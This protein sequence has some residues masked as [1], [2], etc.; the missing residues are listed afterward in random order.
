MITTNGFDWPMIV[1][2]KDFIALPDFIPITF[3]LTVLFSALG[4]VTTFLLVSKLGP[5]SKKLILDPR[6]SDNKFV[7]AIDVAKNSKYGV[8]D[9][10][11]KVKAEGAS[12]VFQKEID[13]NQ[14]LDL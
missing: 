5:G 6:Y 13:N 12:E 8:D 9:I 4:M 7:V 14:Y 10:I 2:G 3:E 11:S 1:G